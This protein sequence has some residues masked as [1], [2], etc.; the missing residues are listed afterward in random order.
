V[1]GRGAVRRR[2]LPRHVMAHVRIRL[3]LTG[4]LFALLVAAGPAAG[5]TVSVVGGTL[6]YVAAPGEANAVTVTPNGTSFDVTDTG[7]ALGAGAG[8]LSTGPS[9]ANCTDPV[10]A[11][12]L[13]LDDGNDDVDLSA[14][15][16]CAPQTIGCDEPNAA[17]RG[18]DGSDRL[19]GGGGDDAITGGAGDDVLTGGPSDDQLVGGDGS[20]T[21]DYSATTAGIVVTVNDESADGP[22]GEFDNVQCENV[23]GGSG[24]DRLSGDMGANL[25]DGGPGQDDLDGDGGP[26]EL[27]G[28]PDADV[29]DYSSRLAP[30]TA[31]LEGDADDGEAGEGDLIRTDVEGIRGG[32]GNDVFTGAGGNDTLQGGNGNDTLDGADGYDTLQAEFGDDVLRG[33]DGTDAL[34]AGDGNDIL[35]GGAGPDLLTGGMGTDVIDYSSRTGSLIVDFYDRGPD[36]EFGEEDIVRPDIEGVNGGAG[37]DKLT[38]STGPV[39]FNGNGGDDTLQ[40]NIGD[41]VLAGGAGK[42]KVA[43]AGGNDQIN[44]GAGQDTLDGGNADDTIDARDGEKD[45]LTCGAGADIV[46]VDP[47]DVVDA[48]CEK[49]ASTA[50]PAVSLPSGTLRAKKRVVRVRIGC[51]S[52]T[53]G[54]CKGTVTIEGRK[55]RKR[56]G[57]SSFDIAPGKTKLVSVKL[58][59]TAVALIEKKRKVAS[60]LVV[61]ARDGVGNRSTRRR[62]VTLA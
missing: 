44:G 24:N 37:K 52:R 15:P 38:A 53:V 54:S 1:Y 10:T 33:G 9:S 41:D 27:A 28:G 61:V 13:T 25:L 55:P 59:K 30:V 51:P 11:M 29:A 48:D 34:L 17:I 19:I 35:D 7:A 22:G 58:S 16:S 14:V 20:D 60:R 49:V 36:G 8:C 56:F 46:S 45:T 23:R 4:A 39:S 50:G 57:R 18:G 6:I 31:D 21:A 43:G 42:D 62:H 3:A 32:N 5:A 26:D 47:I 2:R 40:G 12:D